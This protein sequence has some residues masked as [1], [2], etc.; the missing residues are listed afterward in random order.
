MILLPP[1]LYTSMRYS[2]PVSRPSKSILVVFAVNVGLSGICWS[3][4]GETRAG[5]SALSVD[6]SVPSDAFETGWLVG[7]VGDGAWRLQ[8][9]AKPR[10]LAKHVIRIFDRDMFENYSD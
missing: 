4:T 9:S 8:A 7:E 1:A 2:R 10:M 6:P 3:L 5:G